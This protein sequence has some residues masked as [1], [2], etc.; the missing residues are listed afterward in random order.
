MAVNFYWDANDAS[1]AW[2][3]RLM[4]RNGNVVPTMGHAAA[5][6]SVRHYLKAVEKAGTDEAG[7][8]NKAMKEL[9]IDDGFY[10]NPR[11]QRT[12]GW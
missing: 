8:V 12:A 3:K 2:A 10:G 6:S 7:A 11:I 5:Y 4:A 1:R 9:P